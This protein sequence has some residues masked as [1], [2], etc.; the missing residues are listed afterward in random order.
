[1][2]T[3]CH[4]VPNKLGK[5]DTQGTSCSVSVHGPCENLEYG[6]GTNSRT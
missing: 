3:K 4:L 2:Q 1:M 6:L 5:G